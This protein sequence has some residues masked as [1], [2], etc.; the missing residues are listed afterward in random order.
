MKGTSSWSYRPY[1]PLLYDVGAPYICRIAP[2]KSEIHLEWLACGGEYSVFF[3]KRGE[4][5]F[6]G[7]AGMLRVL[8]ERDICN[9][10]T[11]PRF[12]GMG[13]G[14]A[15]VSALIESAKESGASVIMLEVR[16][17]NA[18]AIALYEKAGFTL[19][20]Q[21]KNFYTL[22]REDALLYNYYID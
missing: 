2:D 1:S 15:L 10:A 20:G 18:A 14:K 16:K 9:V 4:G 5:E 3:R 6:A 17:S 8:D 7:Y 13:V 12:R 21:R 11:S 22:P 19:V